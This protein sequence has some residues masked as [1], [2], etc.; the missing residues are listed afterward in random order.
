MIPFPKTIF[1]EE[2][3]SIICKSTFKTGPSQAGGAHLCETLL[4]EGKVDVP[5]TMNALCESSIFGA[6][7]HIGVPVAQNAGKMCF[8]AL[9][10]IENILV[11]TVH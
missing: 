11:I 6:Q 10:A 2:T 7:V 1:V 4:E 9:D 3:D 5:H 8:P